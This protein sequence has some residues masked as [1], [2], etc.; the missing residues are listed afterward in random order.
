VGKHEVKR[1]VRKAS[2]RWKDNI[3]MD[4]KEIGWKV[5]HWIDMAQDRNT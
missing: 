3:K 2:S 4:L 1:A 5:L